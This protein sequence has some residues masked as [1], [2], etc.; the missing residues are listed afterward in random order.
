MGQ[1]P[2]PA[3]I[4][5]TSFQLTRAGLDAAEAVYTAV[6]LVESHYTGAGGAQ[7]NVGAGLVALEASIA[8]LQG[9][10]VATAARIA[11]VS[12]AFSYAD[13]ARLGSPFNA[14]DNESG[15]GPYAVLGSID[16]DAP[17]PA[18]A[19][20]IGAGVDQATTGVSFSTGLLTTGTTR[21]AGGAGIWTG[22]GAAC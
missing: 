22:W 18:G 20:V 11:T 2:A 19:I 5:A 12:K 13:V 4:G 16:F 8:N 21:A 1:I 15:T 14:P 6:D 10:G 17:L 3:P 7:P 9:A